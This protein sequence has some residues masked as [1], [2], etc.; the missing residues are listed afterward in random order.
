MKTAESIIEY[1]ELIHD[2][3]I[4]TG[5]NWIIEA[6]DKALQEAYLEGEEK[7]RAKGIH[8]AVEACAESAEV[9]YLETDSWLITS[10]VVDKESILRVETEMMKALYDAIDKSGKSETNLKNRL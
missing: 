5:R 6:F 4:R 2:H 3:R 1:V 10:Y 8:E 9:K 7:G